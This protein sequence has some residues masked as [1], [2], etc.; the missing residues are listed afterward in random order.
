MKKIVNTVIFSFSMFNML[1]AAEKFLDIKIDSDEVAYQVLG[2]DYRFDNAENA[3][4]AYKKLARTWHPDKNKKTEA[5][6]V[7]KKINQAHACITKPESR[8]QGYR[9]GAQSSG[10]SSSTS[11]SW[12]NADFDTADCYRDRK[13]R[14]A[15]AENERNKRAQDQAAQAERDLEQK[16]RELEQRERAH[17]LLLYHINTT[18][19]RIVIASVIFYI[20]FEYLNEY[21]LEKICKTVVANELELVSAYYDKKDKKALKGLV[22]ACK[23]LAWAQ[24]TSK[25]IEAMLI[26]IL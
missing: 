19:P 10:S 13:E 5:Q 8:P 14:A 9:A 3:K 26:K 20:G 24:M 11:A 21:Q 1:Q 25:E 7:F 16:E 2:L 15:W 6:E 17:K 12:E 22:Y 18:I 4:K 23:K